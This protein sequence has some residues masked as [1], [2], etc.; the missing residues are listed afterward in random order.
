M[1]CV[2]LMETARESSPSRATGAKGPVDPVGVWAP[3]LEEQF[4]A[5]QHAAYEQHGRSTS[6]PNR[7]VH[8]TES[9]LHR[10]PYSSRA[11]HDH[12]FDL[13]TTPTSHRSQPSVL[14]TR[15]EPLFLSGSDEEEEEPVEYRVESPCT[16]PPTRR[17]DDNERREEAFQNIPHGTPPEPPSAQRLPRA[18]T[19]HDGLPQNHDPFPY[20]H[21]GIYD[22]VVTAPVT[23]HSTTRDY[24]LSDTEDDEPPLPT[25]KLPPARPRQHPKPSNGLRK[26]QTFSKKQPN[27]YAHSRNQAPS[28]LNDGI[29]YAYPQPRVPHR[30]PRRP[31]EMVTP[32]SNG[33]FQSA[34]RQEHDEYETDDDSMLFP[35]AL[36]RSLQNTTANPDYGGTQESEWMRTRHY[37]SSPTPHTYRQPITRRHHDILYD[38]DFPPLEPSYH[39]PGRGVRGV[40]RLR[41]RRLVRNVNV[42][43][44]GSRPRL[45]MTRRADAGDDIDE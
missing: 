21:R 24:D 30:L 6:A 10:S 25:V 2:K 28:P 1:E 44:G 41:R 9:S 38:R 3:G 5:K 12:R 8:H 23:K 18:H 35:S 32:H 37:R 39:I 22:G 14:R 29:S 17:G 34:H 20:M 7:Q 43:E 26:V 15:Q 27:T 4:W 31:M 36:Q 33:N 40:P 19:T 11:P 45:Q 16:R 13:F 42:Y